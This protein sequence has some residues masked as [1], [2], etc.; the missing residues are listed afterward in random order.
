MQSNNVLGACDIFSYNKYGKYNIVFAIIFCMW[1]NDKICG[2]IVFN[3]T[4]E[5][6]ILYYLIRLYNWVNFCSKFPNLAIHHLDFWSLQISPS[7]NSHQ[8]HQYFTS[9]SVCELHK[10]DYFFLLIHIPSLRVTSLEIE[11]QQKNRNVKVHRQIHIALNKHYDWSHPIFER[12]LNVCVLMCMYVMC[13]LKIPLEL[14]LYSNC[15]LSYCIWLSSL[16]SCANEH[17]KCVYVH[18]AYNS[19]GLI[20]W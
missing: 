8:V 15:I 13:Y 7:I 12:H 4:I 11:E 2:Q 1:F 17:A 20:W 3:F 16:A 6:P 14:T 5:F 18:L 9:V 19:V 10:M